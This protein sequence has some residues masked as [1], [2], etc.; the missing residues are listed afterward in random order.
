MEGRS[1]KVGKWIDRGDGLY[2]LRLTLADE[3]EK[4]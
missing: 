3:A 1:V 4:P 2:A